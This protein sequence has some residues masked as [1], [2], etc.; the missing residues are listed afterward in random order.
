MSLLNLPDDNLGLL[1]LGL[2][3]MSTPGNFGQALGQAGMGALGDMQQHAAN[4]QRRQMTELQTQQMRAQMEE[5][6]RAQ[7]AQTALKGYYTGLD[8][9]ASMPDN[10]PGPRRDPMPFDARQ[11]V[12]AGA[13]IAPAFQMQSLLTKAGPEAFTLKPGEVRFEGGRR[14]AELPATTQEPETI[15]V[16]K[17]IYGDGTPAYKAALER[18]GQKVSTHQQPAQ[19]NVNTGQKDAN[20]GAPPKDY[21]WARDAAGNVLTE[22]DQQTGAFRPVAL[23]IGGSKDAKETQQASFAAATKAKQAYDTISQLL[24]HPGTPVVIGL[25][26][27]VDPRNYVWGSEAQGAKALL[28]QAQ[29]Q[30]FLQAFE[31][32]KGGGQITQ[33]EGEKAT[34]A[35]ARLQR[36]Q[37]DEDF[38]KSAA[39]LLEITRAAY[40]RSTGGQELPP[41]KMPKWGPKQRNVNQIMQDADAIL[42]GG[43]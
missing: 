7:Q 40:K 41:I 16:L 38:A 9:D 39:E 26:G 12:A 5:A 23:P 28:E 6:A 17:M 24:Q 25:S 36:A 8:P 13:D 10:M 15:R 27:Q 34:A 11:A 19:V 4:K 37:S 42:N 29:G 3:M 20:W 43:R 22:R 31:S 18:Y 30:A 32:L 35:M 14:V 21:V 1:S 2:R 33:V